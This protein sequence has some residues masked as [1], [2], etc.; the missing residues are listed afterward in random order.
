[1]ETFNRKQ[2]WENVYT[3]KDPDQVSWFEKQE[4]VS[5]DFFK[6]KVAKGARI[7]DIGGGDSYLA[8]ALLDLGFTDI[9]VLDI[10][11][12]ALE[13]A[14]KRLGLKAE[15]ITW[16]VADIVDFKPDQAY[17]VWHDRAVF[18]FLTKEEDISRYR[19]LVAAS[20]TPGGQLIIA[21]FS[22]E[23]PLKCSGIEI[24]QY[25]EESLA[26]LFAADFD[27]QASFRR[28]HQTPFNTQ[29]NFVFCHLVKKA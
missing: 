24:C 18:H 8:E 3:S 25:T 14:K 10:S 9:T 23:G 11:E 5:L 27:V 26:A 13:R 29:Q 17:D 4:P 22:D 12:A 6:T 1:M 16:T 21:T 7:I 15:Q 19:E 28:D 20:I 2:H